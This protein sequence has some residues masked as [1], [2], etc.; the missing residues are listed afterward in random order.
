MGNVCKQLP[1]PLISNSLSKWGKGSGRRG[2][3]YLTTTQLS[4]SKV[5]RIRNPSPSQNWRGGGR[6]P[7]KI[8]DIWAGNQPSR[9]NIEGV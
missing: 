9:G 3:E 1:H 8:E 5:L 7:M 4:I 6:S 2:G